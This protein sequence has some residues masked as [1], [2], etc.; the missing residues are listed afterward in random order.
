MPLLASLSQIHSLHQPHSTVFGEINLPTDRTV[1]K[2]PVWFTPS[3]IL[4]V[5][6]YCPGDKTENGAGKIAYQAHLTE[7]LKD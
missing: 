7:S 5:V 1:F 4:S 3:L 6:S 2:T